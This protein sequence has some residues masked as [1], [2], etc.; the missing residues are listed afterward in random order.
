MTINSELNEIL[1]GEIKWTSKP[2][3]IDI[4]EAPKAKSYKVKWKTE[5]RKEHFCLWS[6]QG[7]TDSMIKKAQ[8][9]N[10]KLFQGTELL[11]FDNL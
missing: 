10:I 2:V 3:G 6:K 9:E 5:S 11:R 1:F 4:F 7:F 8:K